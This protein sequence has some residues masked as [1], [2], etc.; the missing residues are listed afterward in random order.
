MFIRT[1]GHYPEIEDDPVQNRMYDHPNLI[2]L[3]FTWTL[4]IIYLLFIRPVLYLNYK[5]Q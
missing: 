5:I 4:K 1:T 2:V 3:N